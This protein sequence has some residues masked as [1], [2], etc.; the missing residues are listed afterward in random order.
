MI[1]CKSLTCNLG[2]A[3][4]ALSIQCLGK[5]IRN[6]NFGNYFL[7]YSF[8]KRTSRSTYVFDDAEHDERNNFDLIVKFCGT[9]CF[10]IAISNLSSS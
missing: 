9:I 4:T 1:E 7:S 10:S 2:S 3:Y 6:R 8:Y 5:W